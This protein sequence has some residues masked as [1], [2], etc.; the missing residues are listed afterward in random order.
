MGAKGEILRA[1]KPQRKYTV[2]MK[3]HVNA[4]TS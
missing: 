1:I 4:G 3:D 2:N